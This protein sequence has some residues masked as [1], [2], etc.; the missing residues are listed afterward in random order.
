MSVHKGSWKL[1]PET[2][3]EGGV[4]LLPSV[5]VR[6]PREDEAEGKGTQC[7]GTDRGQGALTAPDP[8]V[9]CE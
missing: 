4:Q 7:E 1:H 9:L 3:S 8:L 6:L 5:W 2:R